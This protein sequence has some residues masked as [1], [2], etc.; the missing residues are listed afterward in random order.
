[1]YKNISGPQML[2]ST[3]SHHRQG[4]LGLPYGPGART[5]SLSARSP[6]MG[7]GLDGESAPHHTLL[8]LVASSS[9]TA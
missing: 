6:C 1:M 7:H 8:A 3:S 2:R 5:L 4:A 9:G